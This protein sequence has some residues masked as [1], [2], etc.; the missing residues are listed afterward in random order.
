[1]AFL[2]HRI[3]TNNFLT[4]FSFLRRVP[5]FVWVWVGGV[6]YL[7]RRT[8]RINPEIANNNSPPTNLFH[9]FH[10][11]LIRIRKAFISCIEWSGIE[12]MKSRKFF[13]PS[14]KENSKVAEKSH[15]R[16][17]VLW[18]IAVESWFYIEGNFLQH[19]D[20][21]GFLTKVVE[22]R[23]RSSRK[24]K[25]YLT[26][27]TFQLRLHFQEATFSFQMKYRCHYDMIRFLRMPVS[28]YQLQLLNTLTP[29]PQAT[30]SPYSK[31][32]I[33]DDIQCQHRP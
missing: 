5:T 4:L 32:H 11:W 12:E 22:K 20:L 6:N 29:S 27:N 3:E 33:P 7:L 19:F 21:I 14:M 30:F 18:F 2:L 9:S 31:F 23:C 25:L 17:K 1:M 24:W 10:W 28:K 13:F 15:Y 26:R 16:A 8:Q